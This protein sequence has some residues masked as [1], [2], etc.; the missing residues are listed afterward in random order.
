MDW[1]TL[2]T[3]HLLVLF[4]VISSLVALEAK[5]LLAAVL[6]VGAGGFA[7]ALIDLFLGAPDLAITQMAVEVITL[8]V[9]IRMVLWR[10]DETVE[11]HRDTFLVGSVLFAMG[12][13]L[14]GAWQA[15]KHLPTLGEPQGPLSPGPVKK[16]PFRGMRQ[17][18]CRHAG[19]KLFAGQKT[20][21]IPL[22]W[23]GQRQETAAPFVP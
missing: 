13:F 7:L 4:M 12:L 11:T 8:G 19:L 22:I 15:I 16:H 2:A 23:S 5:D 9:L 1:V 18:D 20:D 10:R 6:C 3:L 21:T 17:P 14:F